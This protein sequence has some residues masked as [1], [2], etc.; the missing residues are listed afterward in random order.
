MN[1]TG[2]QPDPGW[3]QASPAT[4][5][6]SGSALKAEPGDHLILDIGGDIGALTIYAPPGS[7][8]REIEI[9]PAGEPAHRTHNVVRP[10]H[11]GQEIS[12]A[13]VFP[14]LTAGSYLVWADDTSP[15]GTVTIRG[16]QVARFRLPEPPSA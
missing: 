3:Q 16:G 7:T 8:G 4:G 13:A 14:S 9:S 5:T 15:A 11:T 6:A 12:Y 1:Q 10:R 2:Q